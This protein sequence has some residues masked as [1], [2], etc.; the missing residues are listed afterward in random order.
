MWRTHHVVE[1]MAVGLI[2][3]ASV[4]HLDTSRRD[5]AVYVAQMYE[6][7]LAVMAAAAAARRRR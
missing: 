5:V 3:H 4:A 7:A 6:H 1:D 2:R